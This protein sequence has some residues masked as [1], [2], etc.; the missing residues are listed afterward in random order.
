MTRYKHHAPQDNQEANQ[1][2][3]ALR[4][5]GDALLHVFGDLKI[6]QLQPALVQVSVVVLAERQI[7]KELSVQCPATETL[8]MLPGLHDFSNSKMAA[9][10]WNVL[11]TCDAWQHA[12][13]L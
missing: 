7:S 1:E 2:E 12:N 11:Q 3:A 5:C 6:R 10:C 13:A 4:V 8:K 9:T